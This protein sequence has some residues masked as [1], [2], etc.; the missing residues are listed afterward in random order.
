MS[1]K[2]K[3]REAGSQVGQQRETRT[4]ETERHREKATP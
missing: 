3:R 2:R 1:K 4:D